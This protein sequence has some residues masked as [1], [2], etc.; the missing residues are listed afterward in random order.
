M[1]NAFDRLK[2][3]LREEIF[4]LQLCPAAVRLKKVLVTISVLGPRN[5]SPN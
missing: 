5:H 2:K 1:Q 3:E 4:T